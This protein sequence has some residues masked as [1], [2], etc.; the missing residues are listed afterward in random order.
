M[1][2]PTSPLGA[3]EEELAGIRATP[4]DR[5]QAE[6]DRCLR[7]RGPIEPDVE[8]VLRCR[9]AVARLASLIEVLWETCL[10]PWW[11]RI[12]EVLERDI[13][14]RSRALA[15][16]GLA[17]VFEDLEPM[18]TSKGAAFEAPPADAESPARRRRAASGS[19]RVRVALARAR[20]G[21]RVLYSRTNLGDA[22]LTGT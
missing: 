11:P 16:G 3:L 5:A 8:G 19:L 13:L 9:H 20:G 12:R 21:R 14:R 6:I 7:G 4:F 10:E 1:P 15:M 18:I 22:L 17:G 2:L